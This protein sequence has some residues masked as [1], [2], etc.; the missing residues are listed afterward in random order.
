MKLRSKILFPILLV[1]IVAIGI[2]GLSNYYNA[3]DTIMEQLQEQAGNELNTITTIMQL[4][5]S[6]LKT[7]IET[8]KIGGEGYGY[9]IDDRGIIT[10]HPEQEM[11]GKKLD[12]YD[13]GK[14]ILERRNGNLTYGFDGLEKYAVFQAVGGSIVVVE[15]PTEEFIGPLRALKVQI[16]IILL[17][18]ML[19][20]TLMITLLIHKTTIKPINKLIDAMEQAGKG[21]LSARMNTKSSDE[22]G[23]LGESFNHMTENIKTLV[24]NVKVTILKLQQASEI[25]AS[26]TEEVSASTIEVARTIQEIAKGTTNQAVETAAS[27]EMTNTLADKIVA[28][29]EKIKV[30]AAGTTD[31]RLKNERGMKAIHVLESRFEENT[32]ASVVVAE[33]VGALAEKSKSI[34]MIVEAIKAIAG[35]TNLLALNAAIEAARAGEQGRGFSVVADEI[36]KLA[37]QSAKATEEIQSIIGDIIRII[38]TT[39]YTMEEAKAILTNANGALVETKET[40]EGIKGAVEEVTSQVDLLDADI[41]EMDSAKAN[42]LKSIESVSSVSQ[43]TAASTQQISA[44]AEEQTASM[45]EITS[46]LQELNNMV[47]HLGEAIK[48]FKF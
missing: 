28:A 22:M 18:A 42:V 37:E 17:A 7:L 15:V 48:I 6:S 10:V 40:F 44:S 32:K 41:N 4:N 13:W 27:L 29:N 23:R 35:Q 5:S 39:N 12:D 1:M 43:Q 34:S 24:N 16:G 8:L 14:T 47:N 20:A 9:V 33:N 36:R 31:M 11:I 30:T 19:A 21:N 25:I 38:S 3:K 46:S 26:S 2:L 45:E